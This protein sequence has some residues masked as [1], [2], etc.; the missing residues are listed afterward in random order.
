MAKGVGMNSRSTS[1]GAIAAQS[2]SK[3]KVIFVNAA[4]PFPELPKDERHFIPCRSW[5][6]HYKYKSLTRNTLVLTGP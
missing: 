5:G 4:A 6:N 1:R 2:I 3:Y